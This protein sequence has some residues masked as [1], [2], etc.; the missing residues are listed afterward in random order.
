MRLLLTVSREQ[1]RQL[2]V[3]IDAATFAEAN[4]IRRP[5]YGAKLVKILEDSDW[6]EW[7]ALGWEETLRV[8]SIEQTSDEFS[9][10]SDGEVKL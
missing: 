2:V 9:G 1:T 5:Y 4:Q 10:G 7:D 6:D 3:D 8:Q